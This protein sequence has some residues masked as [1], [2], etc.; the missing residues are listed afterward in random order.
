MSS[1]DFSAAIARKLRERIREVFGAD[2]SAAEVVRLNDLYDGEVRY[3]D[4]R[5]AELF[6]ALEH[7]GALA[8]TVVA[9]TISVLVST[10][11]VFIPS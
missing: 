5:M 11:A 4:R 6:A 10:I 8:N 3:L 9:N 1:G 7:R 2:L